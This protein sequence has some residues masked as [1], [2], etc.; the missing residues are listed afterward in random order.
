MANDPEL[1]A[2]SEVYTALKNL[3]S[4]TQKSVVEWRLF[5]ASGSPQNLGCQIL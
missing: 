1:K 2:M 3:D 5:P 4:T